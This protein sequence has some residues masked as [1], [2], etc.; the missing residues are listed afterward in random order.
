MRDRGI[1]SEEIHKYTWLGE[2]SH[3][4][5]VDREELQYW[6]IEKRAGTIKE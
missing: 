5:D 6:E 4:A 3:K 1:N 2:S